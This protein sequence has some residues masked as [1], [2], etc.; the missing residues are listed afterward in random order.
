M[1]TEYEGPWGTSEL[2]VSQ[3]FELSPI[4]EMTP[5]EWAEY[6]RLMNELVE[7]GG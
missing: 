5:Q 6:C 3:P 4:R 1:C 2:V 7:A